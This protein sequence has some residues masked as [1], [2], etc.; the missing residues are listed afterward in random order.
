MDGRY[1]ITSRAKAV[2]NTSSGLL[3]PEVQSMLCVSFSATTLLVGQEEMQTKTPFI[4]YDL[5]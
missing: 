1:C 3:F 2:G 4:P 5:L